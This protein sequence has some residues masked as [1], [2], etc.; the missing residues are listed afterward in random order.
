MVFFYDKNNS[1]QTI[2]SLSQQ[3]LQQYDFVFV[4]VQKWKEKEKLSV[5]FKH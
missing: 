1:G 5:D 4:V 2:P 3:P